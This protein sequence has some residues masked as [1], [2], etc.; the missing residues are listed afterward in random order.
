MINDLFCDL[1]LKK[2]LQQIRLNH[3]QEFKLI[4]IKGMKQ[5][6]V[7][8]KLKGCIKREGLYEPALGEWALMAKPMT[9]ERFSESTAL[10]RETLIGP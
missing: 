6:R 5:V 1:E 3:F 4:N 9:T 8:S 7:K 10:E 2:E